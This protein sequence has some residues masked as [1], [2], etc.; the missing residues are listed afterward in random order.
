M[1]GEAAPELWSERALAIAC[2]Q[3]SVYTFNVYPAETKSDKL[4][5]PV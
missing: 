3:K 1:D 2:K 5:S 4:L